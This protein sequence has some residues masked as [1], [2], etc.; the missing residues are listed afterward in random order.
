MDNKKQLK[1]RIL[2]DGTIMTETKGIKSKK[3]LDYIDLIEEITNAKVYDS[4][5]TN[6]YYEKEI[7]NLYQ[8]NTQS[9]YNK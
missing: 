2:P 9:L 4:E 3:C 7:I 8:E 6:E 1:I 5:F